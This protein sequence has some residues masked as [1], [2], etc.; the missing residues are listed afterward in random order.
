MIDALQTFTLSEPVLTTLSGLLALRCA[1]VLRRSRP[2]RT[3]S[4]P[5]TT[6]HDSHRPGSLGWWSRLARAGS[7]AS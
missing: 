5:A 6:A 2:T 4:R 3:P 1:S 7:D